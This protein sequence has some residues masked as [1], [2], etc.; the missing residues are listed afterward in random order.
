MLVLY[1][2]CELLMKMKFMQS[3]V[4]CGLFYEFGVIFVCGRNVLF[5]EIEVVLEL[6]VM[7][8][9]QYVVD[10]LCEQIQC[11][12]DLVEDIK[13]IELWLV[14]WL[15]ENVDMLC[16]VQIFGVGLLIVMVVIVMMGEVKVFK[17]GC[18]FCVWLGLVL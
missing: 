6:L 11:I 10:S 16:V 2:Q 13:V 15:C 18:E 9:L 8:I 12:K 3:N 4:L 14:Q 1:C 5:S 7:D 17:F